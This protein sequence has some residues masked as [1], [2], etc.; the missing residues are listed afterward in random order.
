MNDFWTTDRTATLTS[1][2]NGTM[3]ARQIAKELGAT[4][5]AVKGKVY[6]MRLAHLLAPPPIAKPRIRKPRVVQV[7]EPVLAAPMRVSMQALE[8]GMCRWPVGANG[9]H[10]FCGCTW[11]GEHGPYCEAHAALAYVKPVHKPRVP[12]EPRRKSPSLDWLEEAA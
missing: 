11:K 3:T 10:V 7:V 6:R 2:L 1:M 4:R 9:E 8:A 12:R 5:A